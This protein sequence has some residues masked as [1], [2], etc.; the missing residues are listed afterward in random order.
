MYIQ[1]QQIGLPFEY[2]QRNLQ[3]ESLIFQKNMPM[4]WLIGQNKMVKES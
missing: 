4:S 2:S 3:V 1:L